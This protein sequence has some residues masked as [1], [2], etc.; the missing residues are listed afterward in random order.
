MMTRTWSAT[1]AGRR[2]WLAGM[3]TLGLLGCA[4]V[5]GDPQVKKGSSM[6]AHQ[7]MSLWDLVASVEQQMPITLSKAEAVLGERF[8]QTEETPAYL[9]LSSK[10]AALRDGLTVSRATL[11]LR[12]SLQFEDKSALAYE[13]GGA[14]VSL[15]QVRAQF[16]ELRLIQS[17]R[18]RSL[19]E[20]TAWALQR[21]WGYI[22][23]SFKE[24][25]PDCLF[26]VAFRKQLV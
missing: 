11:M 13:L 8:E 19:D 15:A 12:P 26:Q 21:P 23:F 17:P 24:R 1:G 20:T 3:L 16:G 7:Q 2:L 25:Q 14:C 5:M 10:G 4:D 22:T 9:L 6:N 18:G